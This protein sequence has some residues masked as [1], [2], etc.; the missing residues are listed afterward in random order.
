MSLPDDNQLSCAQIQQ[1]LTD[2][3]YAARKFLKQDKNVESANTAKTIG[4]A[5]PY[6]GLLIAASAD[7]S[8]TEQIKARALIDRDEHLTFLA[9]QKKCSN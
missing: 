8:N 6:I 2:N 5:V 1:Q 3:E 9:K 7:L 4:S